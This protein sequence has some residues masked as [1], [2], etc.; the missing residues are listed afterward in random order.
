MIT[1]PYIDV[2]FIRVHSVLYVNCRLD[3]GTPSIESIT[4]GFKVQAHVLQAD[5]ASLFAL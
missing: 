3:K 2:L 4:R 1:R 5:A